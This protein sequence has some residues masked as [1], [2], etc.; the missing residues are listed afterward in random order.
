MDLPMARIAAIPGTLSRPGEPVR[1]SWILPF[2]R[3]GLLAACLALIGLL[4]YLDY[5]TGYEESLLL[6]Y[7]VPIALGTWYEGLYLGLTFSALSLSAWVLSDIYAG[8]PTVGIWNLVMG[9]AA[10]GVFTVLLHKLRTVLRELD[11]RV[12]DRTVALRREIAERKRLDKE[13]AEV[14]DRERL[15]LG[16]ELHDGLCQH[17]TGTALTAQTLRQ[18]LAARSAGEVAQ[19]DQ[20]VRYIEEGIDMSR[21]LARGLFSPELEAD[22]LMVALHG[23]AENMTERYGVA[24]SFD[25]DGVL[26]VR[27]TKVAT[28]L[29]RIAQEAMMNAVK[30][31]RAR[32][33]EIRLV[34]TETDLVLEILDDGVGLPNEPQQN[35]LGLRLMAH[36]AALVGADFQVKPRDTGGTIVL[37]KV[38]LNEATYEKT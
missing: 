3:V 35:G 11:Q 6:F 28:Q 29:Y 36:G 8:I 31:A 38:N 20:I 7:L 25:S 2:S 18:R 14:A 23:L 17:L 15:R 26:N 9:A 33:I 34:E 22:G 21:N 1:A 10:Y 16:Q 19:A 13:V 12:R 32:Q 27:D 4:G 24:C 5:L 30:H 37:C